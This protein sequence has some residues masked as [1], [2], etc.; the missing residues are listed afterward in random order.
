MKIKRL[1]SLVLMSVMLLSVGS[2]LAQENGVTIELNKFTYQPFEKM[3]VKISGLTQEQIDGGAIIQIAEERRD[4]YLS[5]HCTKAS[6]LEDGVWTPL[7]PYEVRAYEIR[8]YTS[9]E[10]TAENML[11]RELFIIR[12]SPVLELVNGLNGISKWAVK[13]VQDAIYDNLTTDKVLKDFQKNIT[14][15]EFCEIVVNMYEGVTETVAETA[16]EDTFTDT[17]NE[18]VLK[19]YK[20][21]VVQGVGEGKF[22]CDSPITR[23]EIATM[24]YRAVKAIAPEADYVVAEP[25]VFGDSASVDEWAKE[26]VDYFASKDIIKGD[27][28]NFLPLDNCNCEEA[29]VLVKRIYDSYK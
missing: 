5:G 1:F 18:Y 24:L 15:E 13:E 21:G 20:L 12:G 22:D 19:A 9:E 4:H 10:Y 17:T 6:D 16:A 14:R 26:G 23:Q 7:A 25:K 27:G 2:A 28:T 29:I 11:A 3:E 8:V